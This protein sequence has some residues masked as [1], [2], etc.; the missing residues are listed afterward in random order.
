MIVCA[1][2]FDIVKNT[3]LLVAYR[4]YRKFTA[5][6]K[7]RRLTCMCAFSHLV[8]CSHYRLRM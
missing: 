6:H 8:L 7:I 1:L 4:K 2:A 3:T 5:V